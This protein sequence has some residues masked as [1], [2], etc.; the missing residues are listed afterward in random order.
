MS[1]STDRVVVLDHTGVPAAT[2]LSDQSDVELVEVPREGP[3][4]ADLAGDVLLTLGESGENTAELVGRAGWIH[5]FGT[6]IDHFPHH[7]MSPDQVLTCTRGGSAIP[8]SEWVLAHM[9]AH[10]KRVPDIWIE[11]APQAGWHGELRIERLH[12]RTVTIVGLGGIGVE[13]ARRCL[14]FEMRVLAIRRGDRPSPLAGVEL[15]TDLRRAVAE[16]DHL[17]LAAPGTA[18]TD[19]LI[20]AEVF[21]AC[22]PGIHVVNVGRG[23]LID[24]DALRTALDEGTVSRASLDTVEPEPLPPG[25][26]MF[27]HP[28]VR[29]TPHM[30]WMMPGIWR[31][32]AEYFAANLRHWLEG[33]P[34][35]GVADRGAGY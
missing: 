27:T 35:E 13:V 15:V 9:L 26:W 33:E 6:G 34:L 31:I 2:R 21:A 23:R 19:R 18:E 12:G 16:S 11:A 8:I 24:D 20:D 4:G 25:H 22:K 14:A 28:Q 29:L 17:V 10:V 7:L 30:S 1:S 3:I 5:L 32:H